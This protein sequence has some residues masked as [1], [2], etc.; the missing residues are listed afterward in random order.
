M[1]FA[2][3]I[4]NNYVYTFLVYLDSFSHISLVLIFLIALSFVALLPYNHIIRS[5][6]ACG[7]ASHSEGI[8]CSAQGNYA[9]IIH[10]IFL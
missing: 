9:V 7:I 4:I 2:K 8:A 5:S 10:L 3:N 1:T 6:K